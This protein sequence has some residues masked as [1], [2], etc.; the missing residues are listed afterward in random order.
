MHGFVEIVVSLLS[1]PT[2][3]IN[4][5]VA[6]HGGT[7]L[8]CMTMMTRLT[9]GAS[10]NQRPLVVAVLLACG[11]NGAIQNKAGLTPRMEAKGATADCFKLFEKVG[12]SLSSHS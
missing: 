1:V 3:D 2:I 5:Q 8:H 4:Y 9:I 6:H 11:A 7:A 12:L 10:L